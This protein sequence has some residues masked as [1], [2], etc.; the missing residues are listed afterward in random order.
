MDFLNSTTEVPIWF[1]VAAILLGAVIG[2]GGLMAALRL[3]STRESSQ[4]HPPSNGNGA[5]PAEAVQPK[6]EPKPKPLSKRETA[7]FERLL[8]RQAEIRS[9]AVHPIAVPKPEP[10]TR[11]VAVA[12]EP[13]NDPT[14]AF[15][16]IEA[17]G[18][19]CKFCGETD[20]TQERA[21]NTAKN[22]RLLRYYKCGK[23]SRRFVNWVQ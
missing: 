16:P 13:E 19:R 7:D 10:S 12:P 23:C 18:V 6:P 20:V 15:K 5:R 22:G 17:V 3:L 9:T 14:K 11:T 21:D 1:P 8:K 2:M 4:V